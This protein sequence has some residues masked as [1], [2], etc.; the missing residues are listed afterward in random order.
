MFVCVVL[1][2]ILHVH[3][4]SRTPFTYKTRCDADGE[5]LVAILYKITR[6]NLNKLK[7][8]R[9]KGV[10]SVHIRHA[11]FSCFLFVSLPH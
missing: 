3:L 9:Q 2:I 4:S 7:H 8:T 10:I 11:L 6:A 1:A 5:Q